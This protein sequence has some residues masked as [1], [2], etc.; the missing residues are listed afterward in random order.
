MAAIQFINQR[1][2]RTPGIDGQRAN[3]FLKTPQHHP[4]IRYIGMVAVIGHGSYMEKFAQ[5]PLI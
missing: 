5:V 3:A 2:S 1:T 4:D